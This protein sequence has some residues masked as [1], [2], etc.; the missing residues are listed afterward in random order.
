MAAGRGEGGFGMQGDALG[1]PIRW[2]LFVPVAREVVYRALT[3]DAGR[4]TFWAESTAESGDDLDFVFVNGVRHRARILERTPPSRFALV[5]F[6]GTATFELT[7]APD[8]GTDLLLTHEGV[9][10]DEWIEVHAGWLNV[11]LPLKAAVAFG[12]DLRNHS[13]ARSWDQGYVDQ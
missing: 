12:V 6:G 11:L 8:G 13:P 9:L 1:G 3:T 10:A 4:A 5:Y 7:A 2:R